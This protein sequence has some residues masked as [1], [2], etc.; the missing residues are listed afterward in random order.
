MRGASGEAFPKSEKNIFDVVNS[1]TMLFHDTIAAISTAQGAGAIAIVRLTGPEAWAIAT[2]LFLPQGFPYEAGQPSLKTHTAQHGFIRDPKT[3][4]HID[5]VVVIPYRAPNSYTGDDL[6]EINCHGGNVVTSEILNACLEKGARIARPGEFTQ[7]S[8]LAGK[9][10]LTQAE[11]VLDVIQA[12]TSRQR[13]LAVSAMAGGLGAKIKIIRHDLLTLLTEIVAGI[14]FPDE[15][16]DAPIDHVDQV[17]GENRTKLEK[18]IATARSGHFL[19]EGMKVA[20][21]GKPNAGKSSLLNQLL[22]YDRAIVTNIAGT[23][24]DALK[25]ALDLNGIPVILI[26]TA[27]IRHTEDEIERIGIER[28]AMAVEEADFILMLFEAQEKWSDE[29]AKV[30]KLIGNKP[31]ILIANKVDLKPDFNFSEFLTQIND[32]KSGSPIATLSLSAKTGSGVEAIGTVI[33]NY[34]LTEESL[35]QAG[36]SLNLRQHE[37]CA[38]ANEALQLVKETLDTGLPQDCLA[39]DLKLAVDRLSE[40]CGESVSEEVI[41]EV[42]ANFCIGK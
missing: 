17:V 29:D 8:F 21:V 3:G 42:F 7:R 41:D 33:E 2:D 4:S 32:S 27:G 31:H 10:D 1:T 35:K 11:A 13:Q 18:L 40:V 28:S 36:G 38:R 6:I 26:D 15:V 25:E 39:T 24:R 14:D 9:I 19:R 34:V 12:K 30:I 5:E 16:G 22:N 37:L 20:I 23:T